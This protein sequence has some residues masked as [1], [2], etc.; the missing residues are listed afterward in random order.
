ME[1]LGVCLAHVKLSRLLARVLHK[2]GGCGGR[3]VKSQASRAHG[4]WREAMRK[5]ASFRP[6]LKAQP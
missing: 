2:M 5:T 1:S 3:S 4:R 6:K